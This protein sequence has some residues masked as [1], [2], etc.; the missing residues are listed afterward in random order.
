MQAALFNVHV[1]MSYVTR[2]RTLPPGLNKRIFTIDFS[3]LNAD[4]VTLLDHPTVSS[5]G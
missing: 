1:Q 2:A 4:F 5:F 3:S